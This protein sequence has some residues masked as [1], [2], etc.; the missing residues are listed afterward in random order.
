M[1]VTAGARRR[2]VAIGSFDVLLLT[3]IALIPFLRSVILMGGLGGLLPHVAATAHLPAM[4]GVIEKPAASDYSGII[5]FVP[6]KP[7]EKLVPPPLTQHTALLGAHAKPM[8]IPFDGAYWYFKWPDLR[9]KRDA[10]VV[11]GDPIKANV[12]STDFRILAMEAHQMLGSPI[13]MD[14]CSTM[15]VSIRNGDNRVGAINV[16]LVLKDKG[17]PQSLGTEVLRSSVA[18]QIALDRA[19]VDETLSFPVPASMKGKK[20]DEIAVVIKA[21]RERSRAGAKLAVQEFTLVP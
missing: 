1:Q 2:S 7:K 3:S 16:E 5:L 20:F 15:K 13:R 18:A 6:T 12:H 9:P 8:V 11:K 17:K 21:A 10:R 4:K 19:P 14:C